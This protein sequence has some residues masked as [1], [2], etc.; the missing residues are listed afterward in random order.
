M[1]KAYIKKVLESMDLPYGYEAEESEQAFFTEEEEEELALTLWLAVAFVFMVM[2]ALFESI[3]LPILVATS[4]PMGLVGVVLTNWKSNTAFDSSARIGLVLL[5]GIVVNNA[6]L[7]ASR[8]RHECSL[9]IKAK[10][11][12]DPEAE[13]SLFPGQRK[14]LGGT[15]M[16]ILPPEGRATL[17]RRAVARAVRIRLRS[18]LLTSGTT[19]L[20][21]V[22]LLLSETRIRDWL[23]FLGRDHARQITDWLVGLFPLLSDPEEGQEIWENLALSSI[24]GLISSTILILIAIPALYYLGVRMS[25]MG[26]SFADFARAR[27]RRARAERSSPN[28]HPWKHASR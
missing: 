11:G 25:W 2:A 16:Y 27:W 15:D 10:L 9:V 7:L 14:E 28:L 1:R 4:I 5:F 26:R 20:G 13:A 17:L 8:F 21:L 23:A 22:P 24:G 12:G 19:I 18:I 6:I 3:T